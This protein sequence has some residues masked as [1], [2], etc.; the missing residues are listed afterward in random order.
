MSRL[1]VLSNRV[2]L[3][4]TNG[5]QAGG[6]A[7]ALQDALQGMQGIWVGWNGQRSQ[8]RQYKFD[9]MQQHGIEY[10]T[11]QLSE[12]EYQGYYCGYA[13]SVLWPLLHQ[14]PQYIQASPQDFQT[15]QAVN[16]KF[17]RQ[18]HQIA[19]P[20]DVI[21]VHDYHFF[22]VAHYCR[23]LGMKNKI[24]FFLHI[25]FA[26]PHAWHQ[27]NEAQILAHHIAQYD[28]FGLQI[29]Q[30]Q[31]NCFD[32]LK[33]K[34][35]GIETGRDRL[36]ISSK[37]SSHSIE[38]KAY[39]ISVHPK[40]IQQ[41]AQSTQ[42][43]QYIKALDLHR[44]ADSK[45]IISVDRIDYSKG[46]LEKIQTIRHYLT[47]Q[48]DPI[49]FQQLQVASPC[50]LEVPVYQQLYTHFKAEVERL[51]QDFAN[52]WTSIFH[53]FYGSLPHQDLLKR[54]RDAD[55]CWVNSIQDG[56]NLVA[57]EFIAAQDP[58]DPG[59]LMLSKYAGATEQM[60]QAL[61]FDPLNPVQTSK[62]L[63]QALKMSRSERQ[64][65]YQALFQGLCEADILTWR[66]QILY[67]LKT[68]RRPMLYRPLTVQQK[69]YRRLHL[70]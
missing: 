62:V 66:N 20:E 10:H 34:I 35:C 70:S 16:Q 48:K 23:Q 22:S 50:R 4:N 14:Q 51:N 46:L 55:V 69:S 68:A 36:T 47:H 49:P 7:I 31:Q 11:C 41:R 18:L 44:Q 1:I 21:W 28:V 33:R 37:T 52:Q 2:T 19:R 63:H 61:I 6:L 54:Y 9:F 17:A 12:A 40:A 27:L 53:S 30:H 42:H 67:D 13:N 56:M 38:I 3:P 32:F 45:T 29:Q 58:D 24:G 26:E 39:P 59:V 15:Y 64:S 43:I 25:P 65:R 57:K 60:Q 5:T 8:Q